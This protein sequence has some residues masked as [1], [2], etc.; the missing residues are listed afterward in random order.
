MRS[1]VS[2]KDKRKASRLWEVTHKT[3]KRLAKVGAVSHRPAKSGRTM[4]SPHE[5]KGQ[6]AD[7][8]K[9]YRTTSA[10]RGSS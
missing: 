1:L 7:L 6:L 9:R 2:F 4:T 3:K 10:Q 5:R 8:P